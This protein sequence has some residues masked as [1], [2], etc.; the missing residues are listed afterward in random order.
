[1]WPSVALLITVI[2]TSY[3]VQKYEYMFF[4]GPIVG[5][6]NYAYGPPYQLHTSWLPKH[7]NRLETDEMEIWDWDCV[8]IDTS[9]Q[10]WLPKRSRLASRGQ[11]FSRLDRRRCFWRQSPLPFSTYTFN[12]MENKELL[13]LKDAR[14][15]HFICGHMTRQKFLFALTDTKLLPGIYK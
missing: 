11:S 7:Q 12:K 9:S 6:D 3:G 14:G 5:S 10:D 8:D 15:E 1:M 13:L 2:R 4:F